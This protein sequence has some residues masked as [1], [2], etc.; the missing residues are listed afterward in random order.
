MVGRP[1]VR[2]DRLDEQAIVGAALKLARNRLA[3]L[4]MRTLADQLEVSV[5]ALYKHVSGRDEL[6]ALVVDAVL[7]QAPRMDAD[8]GD[9]W[10]ALRAQVLGVRALVDRYPGLDEAVTAHSPRSA[11]ADEL[12]REGMAALQREGVSAGDAHKVYRAVTWLWLGS[13]AALEGRARRRADIDTFAEALDILIV[14]LKAHLKS[15]EED[16]LSLA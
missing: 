11:K 4:T 10:L 8:V 5:G 15:T 2:S 7:D 6:L 9:G 13:R 3:E 14:G 16:S 12:R 1:R